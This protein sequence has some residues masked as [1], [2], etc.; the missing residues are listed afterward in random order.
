MARCRGARS[1]GSRAGSIEHAGALIMMTLCRIPLYGALLA[2]AACGDASDA[3]DAL[4]P[5]APGAEAAG[6]DVDAAVAAPSAYTFTTA[7]SAGDAAPGGGQ[8]YW[9]FHADELNDDGDVVFSTW[10]H[11]NGVY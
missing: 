1:V 10:L 6:V 2:V 11:T 4:T 8:V 3:L 7:V 5:S 9:S